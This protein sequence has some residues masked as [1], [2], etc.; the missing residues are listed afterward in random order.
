MNQTVKQTQ[1]LPRK[2][3]P[4]QWKVW[5]LYAIGFVPAVWTFYLG[6]T[7]N[8]GADPVKSFEHSLGLWALRFLMLTLCIT[9]LRDITGI[10]L[11]RYRR[12]LGLL[13]FYY[14]MMHFTVYLVLDQAMN[15]NVVL[16]DI[17]KR[18]FITIGMASLALLVPLALTSNNWS[19]RKLGKGWIKLHK[20]V[21]VAIAG[22]ALH[23]LL[24]VKSWPAEPVIYALLIAF[25]LIWRIIPKPLRKTALKWHH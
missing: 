23:F 24:S 2:R 13:A 6:S 25:L 21:Y 4:L 7:G 20:L 10:S 18:P 8:L 15:L 14:A 22:G 11:L 5:L 1:A 19:I 3:K 17:A 9:P 16:A 12:A